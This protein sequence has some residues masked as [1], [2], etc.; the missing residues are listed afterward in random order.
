[1]I[2]RLDFVND[3]PRIPEVGAAQ[4]RLQ[5]FHQGG[6]AAPVLTECHSYTGGFGGL[7]VRDDVPATERVDRL[8]RVTDQ[9]QRGA[10]GER[11]VDHLPLHGV[12][13]LELV[14]HHDRPPL[15]HPLLSRRVVGLQRV[16]QPGEQVV[17]AEDAAPPLADF[18][19]SA[20]VF[21]EADA[22]RGARIGFGGSS[23][24]APSPG[25]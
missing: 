8:L 24:A 4:Q 12:G 23:A 17:V 14:D 21:R 11:A 20:N 6:V 1:M 22:D 19:F 18:Q 2:L 9:D 15:V 13:V 7:E 3:D 25:G 10:V 5:T 16:G